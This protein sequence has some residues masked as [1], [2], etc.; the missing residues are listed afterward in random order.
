MSQRPRPI[1]TIILISLITSFIVSGSLYLLHEKQIDDLKF[2]VADLQKRVP[3]TL[4]IPLSQ[5]QTMSIESTKTYSSSNL[6]FQYPGNYKVEEKE[7]NP[8]VKVITLQGDKGK[9]AIYNL[10]DGGPNWIFPQST[11]TPGNGWL[12]TEAEE[13][14]TVGK[15]PNVRG[16]WLFYD[17]D[18][19]E[20][21]LELHKIFDS[22]QEV[23]S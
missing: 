12:P 5:S 8:G 17:K 21:K 6:S 18:N 15:A 23:A 20:A 14:L 1:V 11:N 9:M 3:K 16:V 2:E 19:K 13:E 4:N 22:I 10:K 7:I